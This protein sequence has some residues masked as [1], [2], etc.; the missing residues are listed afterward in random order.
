MAL[1]AGQA[2]GGDKRGR[3]SAA[4][5]VYG[6]EAYPLLDLRVDEHPDPIHEL[7]R[8]YGVARETLLPFI[9]MLPTK[10]QPAGTFDFDESRKRGL[11][12][13]DQ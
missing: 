12:H 3:Q 13:D 9:N 6:D 7:S 1:E 8:I 10:A 5:K 11:L 4:L 2:A